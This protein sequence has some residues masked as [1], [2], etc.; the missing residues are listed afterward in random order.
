[1]TNT[2][3]VVV[4]AVAI[5]RFQPITAEDVTVRKWPKSQVPQGAFTATEKVVGLAPK[6]SFV[7]GEPL[8]EEKLGAGPGIGPAIPEGYRAYTIQAKSVAANIAGFVLPGN[9]VDVLLHLRGQ[10]NDGSGGGSTRTLLQAV[11]VLAVG[12]ELEAPAEN[13]VNDVQSVTLLVTPDQANKLDLGQGVGTLSLSLR[14]PTD[15]ADARPKPVTVEDFMRDRY[16]EPD[17]VVPEDEK[18]ETPAAEPEEPEA[19]IRQIVTLRAGNRG[20]VM[21]ACFPRRE[22]QDV[23]ASATPTD[24]DKAQQ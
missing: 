10:A 15:T 5:P 14:N 23:D 2:V 19:E 20:S 16:G 4:A 22:H 8:F 17:R 7:A 13:R 9:C 1:V 24:T 12:P 6:T 18:N 21:V 11:E 3:P